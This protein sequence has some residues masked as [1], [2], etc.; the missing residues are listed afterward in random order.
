MSSSS[1]K[2]KGA[3]ALLDVT[4]V[5]ADLCCSTRHVFRLAKRGLIPQP[6][7]L[8]SLVRWKRAAIDAWLQRGCPTDVD[9]GQGRVGI[10]DGGRDGR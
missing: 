1:T 2:S 6:V 10:D 4:Q 5:A 7:R 3:P 8:G 9:E